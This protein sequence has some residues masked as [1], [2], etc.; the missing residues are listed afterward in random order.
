M[1]L[2]CVKSEKRLLNTALKNYRRRAGSRS[3][4]LAAAEETNVHAALLPVLSERDGILRLKEG[5]K[6]NSEGF[7]Q[8]A[9]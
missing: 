2:S 7:S 9:T 5:H 1:R 6:S 4:S 3:Y 8:W